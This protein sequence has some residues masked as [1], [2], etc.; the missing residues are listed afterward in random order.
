MLIF[1]KVRFKNILSYGNNWTEIPLN[2]K[3]IILINGLNGFGKSTFLDAIYFAISGRPYRNIKC[4]NLV[5]SKNKRNLLVELYFSKKQKQY[6]IIRGLEPKIFEIY[7]NGELIQETSHVKDYQSILEQIL[8][9]DAKSFKQ[10][11][12]MSSRYYVPFMDLKSTEKQKFIENILNI[13]IFRTMKEITKTKQLGLNSEI[14]QCEKD[15]KQSQEHLNQLKE[16][17]NKQT[18]Y[19]QQQEKDIKEEIKKLNKDIEEMNVLIK[20]RNFEIDELLGKLSKYNEMF[21]NANKILLKKKTIENEVN[22]LKKQIMFFE[23]NDVC[24]TCNQDLSDEEKQNNIE[25]IKQQLKDIDEKRIKI[26]A[27][28]EKSKKLSDRIDKI[29]NKINEL[30]EERT[31][32]QYEIKSKEKT[33]TKLEKELVKLN[34]LEF[35][36][37]ENPKLVEDKIKELEKELLDKKSE[38]ELYNEISEILS[39]KGIKKYIV[40]KYIPF[41]NTIVNKYLEIFESPYRIQ[42]DNMFNVTIIA[43]SYNN[44][45]Y[46]NLSSGEKQRVDMALLFSFLELSKVRNSINSNLIILDEIMDNSLDIEGIKGVFN[47]FKMLKKKGYT[48]LI[49]SHREEIAEYYDVVVKVTKKV[50]SEVEIEKK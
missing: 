38:N 39:E 4:E 45:G 31:N 13:N 50:F 22:S 41:L 47:I 1:E 29:T 7:C 26:E 44:L 6:K 46:D 8:G 42:F 5:N 19:M 17:L 27:M 11:L 14:K 24:P 23:T 2:T 37:K 49:V 16:I 32:L 28:L 9:F 3:N 40:D 35:I 25:K 34:E 36:S 33:I 18:Q 10:T 20:E 15:I 12:M 21:K 48:I 43:R 30:K